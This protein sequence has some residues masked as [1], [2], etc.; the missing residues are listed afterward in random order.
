MST[1]WNVHCV[2]CNSTHGFDDANHQEALMELLCKHADAIATLA[3]L[4]ASDGC[5]E[6]RTL[7]GRI[8]PAW[9]AEHRGHKLV[10]ISEYGDLL[11]DCTEYVQCK[12]GSRQRCTLERGHDGDHN[13]EA[14]K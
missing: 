12:C 11:T 6:L 2:T 5:V 10:P 7:W 13:T 1:D 8:D 4:V 3:P 9:F 14:R